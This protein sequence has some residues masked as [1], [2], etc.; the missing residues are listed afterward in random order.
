MLAKKKNQANAVLELVTHMQALPEG[1]FGGANDFKITIQNVG[2]LVDDWSNLILPAVGRALGIDMMAP[3]EEN[4]NDNLY[5]LTSENLAAFRD[6]AAA[7]TDPETQKLMLADATK[8]ESALKRDKKDLANK[9]AAMRAGITARLMSAALATLV[10]RLYSTND[11]LLK[12]Q[13]ETFKR[14]T[15]LQ[16][17]WKSAKFSR[18]SLAVILTMASKRMNFIQGVLAAMPQPSAYRSSPDSGMMH[19]P[20]LTGLPNVLQQLDDWKKNNPQLYRN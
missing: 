15:D 14:Q 3:T 4:I 20:S 13:Y 11:R 9:D 19:Q 16:S 12:D 7:Q 6:Q 8:F 5:K 18:H 10:A 1:T 17:A 2:E